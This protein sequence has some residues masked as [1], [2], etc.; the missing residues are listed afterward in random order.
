MFI[1]IQYDFS[2]E[3]RVVAWT[4]E[5]ERRLKE[6]QE[7]E[8]LA[9]EA[10]EVEAKTLLEESEAKTSS[11]SKDV[12]ENHLAESEECV[13]PCFPGGSLEVGESKES[14]MIDIKDKIVQYSN[15][16]EA[17]A[18]SSSQGLVAAPFV[19][20]NQP[21]YI[22]ASTGILQPLPAVK[23]DGHLNTHRRNSSFDPKDFETELDPFDRL[24]LKTLDDMKELDQVLQNVHI[25]VESKNFVKDKAP[26][27]LNG[28]GSQAKGT[29]L[30]ADNCLT[31]SVLQEPKHSGSVPPKDHCF[32]NNSDAMPQNSAVIGINTQSNLVSYK[33]GPVEYMNSNTSH[34][35]HQTQDIPVSSCNT[36]IQP[37][38]PTKTGVNSFPS[39]VSYNN[40]SSAT[41]GAL[42]NGQTA[43]GSASLTSSNSVYSNSSTILNNKAPQSHQIVSTNHQPV[44]NMNQYEIWREFLQK[45]SNGTNI[46]SSHNPSMDGVLYSTSNTF[47]NGYVN[48]TY[49]NRDTINTSGSKSQANSRS[50]TPTL[51]ETPRLRGAKSTPDLASL[52]NTPNKE[53]PVKTTVNTTSPSAS[54]LKTRTTATTVKTC[55]NFVSM[56]L[57]KSF[58]I[59]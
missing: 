59:T 27:Q 8:R 45:N 25:S 42:S 33:P 26:Q 40:V 56:S 20:V 50:H 53:L 3:E 1:F 28:S 57:C 47:P 4:D 2:L 43:T 37:P 31:G 39:S 10:A 7:K 54:V 30:E 13:E 34:M 5:R 6:E 15:A 23:A 46:S 21:F 14:E 49:Q 52:E 24:E 41:Y 18:T 55:D 22:G 38:P 51:P 36:F 35:N 11:K 9:A 16:S 58:I 32:P 17:S 12:Q 48:V 19:P 29:Q 44:N